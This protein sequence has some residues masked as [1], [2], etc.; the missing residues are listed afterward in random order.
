MKA[1][2]FF[3]SLLATAFFSCCSSDEPVISPDGGDA[4]GDPQFLTVNLVTSGE[5]ESTRAAGDQTIGDPTNDDGDKATYEEGLKDENKVTSIRFYFFDD[6][7]DPAYVKKSGNTKVNYLDWTNI[8]EEN[9]NNMP[10]VEKILSAMLILQTPDGDEMPNT[11]VAIIN[12]TTDLPQGAITLAALKTKYGNY[13]KNNITAGNFVMSNSTYADKNSSELMEVDVK[14]HIMSSKDAALKVP[15]DI[16]VERTVAKVRVV[17]SLT[18]GK[19]LDGGTVLYDPSAKDDQGK[20]IVDKEQKY[21]TQ[22]IYVKFLGWNATA[23]ANNSR[24]IK[25]INPAWAGNLLGSFGPW[26][27]ADYSR[28]FWAVN[29]NDADNKE[30]LGYQYGAFQKSP[31]D[32]PDPDNLFQAQA[33]TGFDKK[34]N[35]VYV[36]ENASDDFA[37]GSG[38]STAT[39]VIIAA[40]LVDENGTAIEFAEYASERMAVSDLTTRFAEILGFYKK[41]TLEDNSTNYV[42]IAPTDLRIMTATEVN[43]GDYVE[44]DRYKVYVQLTKTAESAEWY[45]SNKQDQ[46]ER[47]AL[48]ATEINQTLKELG[49][50]KVWTKGYTYYYFDI[51][52]G[53]KNGVVRNHIYDASLTSLVG[54]G[55]PVYNPDEIIYP[56]KPTPETDT[57]LAARINILSWRVVKNDVPLEW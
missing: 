6:N 30:T 10:N 5:S 46:T 21:N 54:L 4:A 43:N 47:D 52:H 56:E 8:A 20:V 28:S 48:A 7:D 44:K 50:A 13:A 25:K 19:T 49:S 42:K 57:Y 24:L 32:A 16:Y 15:V 41:E 37:T 39:K 12:P 55:T 2:L 35:W 23:V 17:C 53:S 3:V 26:N 11:M 51:E 38:A 34:T 1:K 9:N 18:P 27:W 29:V 22:K 33:Q 36:N 31:E 14:N 45:P 40:Q